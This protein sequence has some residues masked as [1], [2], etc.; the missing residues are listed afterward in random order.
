MAKRVSRKVYH[1]AHGQFSGFEWGAHK[2][3]NPRCKVTRIT[4]TGAVGT[5]PVAARKAG[6]KGRAAGRRRGL[7]R[8]KARINWA[9]VRRAR[10]A[11]QPVRLA[12]RVS[13][14]PV[15]S[16]DGHLVAT[17]RAKAAWHRAQ[18]QQIDA[19]IAE[20]AQKAE[21]YLKG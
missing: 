11:Q 7:G 5:A 3:Y 10:L 20:F 17:M 18:A 14:A 21:P 4:D 6:R 13:T 19:H 1:C 8:R 2:K 16:K 9:A 15:G 12:L